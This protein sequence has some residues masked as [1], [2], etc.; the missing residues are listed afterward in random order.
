MAEAAVRGGH[1]DA[2]VPRD[3]IHR[4]LEPALGE[5]LARGLQDALAV[6]GSVAAQR[7]L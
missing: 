3:L 5:E 7:A 2:R 4:H 6:T 1:A